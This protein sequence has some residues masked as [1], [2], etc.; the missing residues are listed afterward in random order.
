MQRLSDVL[1][2]LEGA[3]MNCESFS[4]LILKRRKIVSKTCTVNVAMELEG[5]YTNV[6]H[7]STK[8]AGFR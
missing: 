8:D 3:L 4:F 1:T 7:L 6:L 5:R 2:F